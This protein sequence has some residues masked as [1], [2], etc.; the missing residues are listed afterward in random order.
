M[1]AE[2]GTGLANAYS[3]CCRDQ[4]PGTGEYIYI[5]HSEGGQFTHMVMRLTIESALGIGSPVP[6]YWVPVKNVRGNG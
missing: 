4:T 3:T 6:T 5:P 2:L 1:V